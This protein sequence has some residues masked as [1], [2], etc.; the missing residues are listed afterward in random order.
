MPL[1]QRFNLNEI[2]FS[3][4]FIAL[5]IIIIRLPK[6]FPLAAS[7]LLIAYGTFIGNFCDTILATPPLDLFDVF[8]S[9]HYELFDLLIF[10]GYGCYCYVLIYIYDRL[11]VKGIINAVFVLLSAAISFCYEYIMLSFK[12]F[13]YKSWTL[14]YSFTSY[15]FVI[16]SLVLFYSFIV[17]KFLPEEASSVLPPSQNPKRS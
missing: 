17:K 14:A 7:I 2:A 5:T 8:D 3:I 16:L 13:T 12:V 11:H 15:L 4:T 1:P 6:R 9:G 10:F